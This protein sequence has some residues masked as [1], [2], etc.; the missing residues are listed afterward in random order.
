MMS[1][2]LPKK[3]SLGMTLGDS[4]AESSTLWLTYSGVFSKTQTQN[5]PLPPWP[6]RRFQHTTFLFLLKIH[7]S[8]PV[9]ISSARPCSREVTSDLQLPTLK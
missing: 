2:A 7:S 6:A 1:S 8:S 3:G 9:G 4:H 5:L